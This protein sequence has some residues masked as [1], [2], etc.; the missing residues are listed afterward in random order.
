MK[1][2]FLLLSILAFYK[3]DTV[4]DETTLLNELRADI[5]DNGK[6]DCKRYPRKANPD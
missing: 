4:C 2:I 5:I 3:A 6:L 1:K